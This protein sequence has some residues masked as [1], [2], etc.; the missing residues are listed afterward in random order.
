MADDDLNDDY[1]GMTAKMDMIMSK[2]VHLLKFNFR[3]H[4]LVLYTVCVFC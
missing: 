3:M 4:F 2:F 1:D